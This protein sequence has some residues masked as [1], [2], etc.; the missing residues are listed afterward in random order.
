[1]ILLEK[2]HIHCTINVFV[3]Y[4]DWFNDRLYIV[5]R[6]AQEFFTYMETSPLPVKGCKNLGL[7]SVLRVFEQGGIFI[8]PHLLW[9]GAS[10]FQV[11]SEG[12]HDSVAFYETQG[13]VEIL[14]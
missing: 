3:S 14:F 5:L 10:V 6:P 1:M 4:E 12:P 7:C 2:I 8:A 13:G 9:Q 11:S